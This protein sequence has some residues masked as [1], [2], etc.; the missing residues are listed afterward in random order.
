MTDSTGASR[1]RFSSPE[2]AVPHGCH[3]CCGTAGL[4]PRL[5][6]VEGEEDTAPDGEL[7]C[8]T[9]G[10]HSAGPASMTSRGASRSPGA[11]RHSSPSMTSV[12]VPS[13]RQVMAPV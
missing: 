3:T 7:G 2:V 11:G 9:Q 6:R 5:V 1:I 10:V 13:H 4:G 12:R 8:G